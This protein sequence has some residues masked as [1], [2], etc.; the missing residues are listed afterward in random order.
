M[1]GSKDD[2]TLEEKFS[3]YLQQVHLGE[4]EIK[5]DSRSIA[6]RIKR[7]F[8]NKVETQRR[9]PLQVKRAKLADVKS[10]VVSNLLRHFLR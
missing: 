5:T 6:S 7:R 3:E 9:P 8:N 1:L 10:F 4:T 2:K